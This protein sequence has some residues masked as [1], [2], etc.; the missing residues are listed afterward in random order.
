MYAYKTVPTG[1][2]KLGL[3]INVNAQEFCF[4]KKKFFM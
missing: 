1:S 2:V 3:K 4:V